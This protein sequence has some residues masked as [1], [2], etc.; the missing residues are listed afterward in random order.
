MNSGDE[1]RLME[2]ADALAL[3]IQ[4]VRAEGRLPAGEIFLNLDYSAKARSAPFVFDM[5]LGTLHRNGCSAI[6]PSSEPALYA[7]EQMRDGDAAL[8][9]PICRPKPVAP[10]KPQLDDAFD[11]LLGA[12]SFVDQFSSVLRERG[13]EYRQSNRAGSWVQQFEQLLA[14][15]GQPG[16][17]QTQA[18]TTRS[19]VRTV[20]IS[21]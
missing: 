6:P 9:C 20:S 2:L 11:V 18:S 1:Q 14:T 19:S 13:R 8:S 5:A 16:F 4:Q 12:L 15:L 21:L 17:G 7:L 3:R 10:A